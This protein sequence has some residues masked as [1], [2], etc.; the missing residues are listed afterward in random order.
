MQLRPLPR[1]LFN[2]LASVRDLVAAY[3]RAIGDTGHRVHTGHTGHIRHRAA[4]IAGTV[5]AE[6]PAQF[7]ETLTL[8]AGAFELLAAR[9]A[10][11][12]I[13]LDTCVAIAT[14]LSL[15]HLGQQRFLFQLAFVDFRECLARTQDH[16]D[17]ETA[18]EEGRDQ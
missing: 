18:D 15:R 1:G 6:G 3:S 9:R 5:G 12:E 4:D 10:Y 14:R 2:L 8:G 13:A 17:E 11:L 16:I 7:E